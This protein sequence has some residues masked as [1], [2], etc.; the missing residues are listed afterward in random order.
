M[1]QKNK[2]KKLKKRLKGLELIINS[3]C[4]TITN[5]ANENEKVTLSFVDG[6]VKFSK[7]VTSEQTEIKEI[8]EITF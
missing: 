2:I 6:I 1:P 5:S 3:N 4:L 7:I 8:S